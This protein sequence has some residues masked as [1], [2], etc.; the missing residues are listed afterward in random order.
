MKVGKEEMVGLLAAVEW[1]LNQD[2]EKLQQSYEDQVT[3][4][5]EVFADTQG[6]T[7]HRSFPLRSRATHAP[8]R[9]PI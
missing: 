4:Y 9:N 8:H 5:T 1:Y 6:V 7:V 2:H 3:Y